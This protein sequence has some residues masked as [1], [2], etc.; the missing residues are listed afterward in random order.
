MK[1]L[2]DTVLYKKINSGRM[3]LKA[4]E[5]TKITIK[6]KTPIQ[7]VQ[8]AEKL[9]EHDL[10]LK[11]S[12]SYSVDFNSDKQDSVEISLGGSEPVEYSTK[13]GFNKISLTTPEVLLNNDFVIKGRDIIISR[14]KIIETEETIE[15]Y[16]EGML[17]AHDYNSK[18]KLYSIGIRTHNEDQT[19]Q[20]VST[21]MINEP[22]RSKNG[23]RDTIKKVDDEWVIERCCA[24]INLKNN[25]WESYSYMGYCYF[26]TEIKNNFYLTPGVY[27]DFVS[28][29]HLPSFNEES[30][31]CYIRVSDDGTCKFVVKTLSNVSLRDF[32]KNITIVLPLK[33]KRY[34]RL[35]SKLELYTFDGVTSVENNSVVPCRMNIR[36]HGFDIR[37]LS[38]A[39]M[40]TAIYNTDKEVTISINGEKEYHLSTDENRKV[41]TT[42]A[43]LI[44]NDILFY[45]RGAK[46]S[47]FSLLEG[48]RQEIINDYIKR[49]E[50]AY[51]SEI[52]KNESSIY[53]NKYKIYIETNQRS[54]TLYIDEPLRI[55]DS[56]YTDNRN[57]NTVLEKVT[58]QAYIDSSINISLWTDYSKNNVDYVGY[59]LDGLAF[60]NASTNK[61]LLINEYFPSHTLVTPELINGEHIVK[62]FDKVYLSIKASRLESRDVEGL[63]KWLERNPFSIIYQLSEPI[64]T[65][66]E[67]NKLQL[68]VGDNSKISTISNIPI[69]SI[70]FNS[71]YEFDLK[72]KKST[73]YRITFSSNANAVLNSFYCSGVELSNIQVQRGKNT[74]LIT[75]PELITDN[76]MIFNG[77]GFSIFE[78]MITESDAEYAAY[79]EGNKYLG[80]LTEDNK[81]LIKVNDKEYI[82]DV[83]LR[84]SLDKKNVD[85][86]RYDY[87]TDKVIIERNVDE[88]LNKIATTIEET[89]WTHDDLCLTTYDS[90]THINFITNLPISAHVSN[91]GYKIKPL[92]SV[93]LY[94]IVIEG[95]G[96]ISAKIDDSVMVST[97]DNIINILAPSRMTESKLCLFGTGAYTDSVMAIRGEDVKTNGYF[98]G[99]LSCFEDKLITDPANKNRGKYEAKFVVTGPEYFYVRT[100]YLSEPLKSGDYLERKTDGIYHHIGKQEVKLSEDDFVLDIF[101]ESKLEV[102]TL[103]PLT[104]LTTV[105]YEE[106]LDNVDYNT[107][108]VVKFVSDRNGVLHY[109]DLCGKKLED[110]P[111]TRG[112]NVLTI[113]T[114]SILKHNSLVFDGLGMTI[115]EVLIIKHS[116]SDA[117]DSIRYFEGT[118]SS[119]ESEYNAILNKYNAVVSLQSKN[120]FNGLYTISNIGGVMYYYTDYIPIDGYKPYISN[121]VE[122]GVYVG[123]LFLYDKNRNQLY[124]EMI[125]TLVKTNYASYPIDSDIKYLQIRFLNRYEGLQIEEGTIPTDYV[126]YYNQSVTL[127]LST[128]LK[129]GD[130]IVYREGDMYHYN[131]N[132]DRYEKVLDGILQ[133]KSAPNMVF[134][135]CSSVPVGTVSTARYQEDGFDF[136]PNTSYLLRF[137]AD[138]DGVLNFISLGGI[139]LRDVI[140]VKGTNSRI[141]NMS[142]GTNDKLTIDGQGIAISKM[143]ITEYI[144]DDVTKEI[145]YF[146]GTKSS[147]DNKT[148][149]I[150]SLSQDRTKE[151]VITFELSTPLHAGEIIEFR[152]Y[153]TF[154][155]HSDGREERL[156]VDKAILEIFANCTI[157]TYSSVPI[158]KIT[159]KIYEQ[160][161]DRLQPVTTYIIKFN[162]SNTGLLDISLGGAQKQVT[163][164]KGIN[165]IEITTPLYLYEN[166]LKLSAKSLILNDVVIIDKMQASINDINNISYFD[167]VQ[168]VAESVKVDDK[169]LLSI[170]VSNDEGYSKDCNVYLTSPLLEYDSLVWDNANL[171]H[172]HNTA[173][174][175]NTHTVSTLEEPYYETITTDALLLDVP[176]QS[177][178][179][180]NSNI[181]VRK[182][183]TTDG[184]E[185]NDISLRPEAYYSIIFDSNKSGIL[186]QL[187]LGGNGLRNLKIS[188]GKNRIRMKT[189]KTIND[190]SL[191]LKGTGIQIKEVLI[192]EDAENT[193]SDVPYFKGIRHTFDEKINNK[194]KVELTAVSYDRNDVYHIDKKELLLNSPL[195]INDRLTEKNGSIYHIHKTATMKLDGYEL[196]KKENVLSDKQ[197]VVFSVEMPDIKGDVLITDRFI[198]EDISYDINSERIWFKDSRIYLSIEQS[199]IKKNN[200]TAFLEES[201]ITIFYDLKRPYEEVV[202]MS[203]IYLKMSNRVNLHL[204][205]SIP[206]KS[207]SL[208]YDSGCV[209]ISNL[210]TAAYIISNISLDVLTQTWESDYQLSEIEW[211][212]HN[213]NILTTS[214]RSSS[215][216]V[217]SR[218]IQAKRII[219]NGIYDKDRMER[220]ID[221]YYEKKE[222]T[223]EEYAELKE[224]LI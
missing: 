39:Q 200:I 9:I 223:R 165:S 158:K 37:N 49:M 4:R 25:I 180:I 178:I 30:T 119:Y 198:T 132:T 143:I 89:D 210:N 202:D 5:N 14:V 48:D 124:T 92:E 10:L 56:I 114:P 97:K 8:L 50:S 111:V 207:I 197:Y 31:G 120:L 188:E 161:I 6:S 74:F 206:C 44:E 71:M 27:N 187:S 125:D 110:V 183:S 40:Y 18:N 168:S 84:S 42:P 38:P 140:V 21:I 96:E 57:N 133:L 195:Y 164:I 121:I 104:L 60:E 194:Y 1:A 209:N 17:S 36:N 185:E 146:E 138:K 86:L 122:N 81:Y 99:K 80:E 82:F 136:K 219:E 186:D 59:C 64:H 199:K 29:K 153:G 117:I 177:R 53:N 118:Q 205:T 22:L 58:G 63:Y 224:M 216:L 113:V 218:Y 221:R 78:V 69:E 52:V 175:T 159:S 72:L 23:L 93:Q 54:K 171:K 43:E 137:D 77:K 11:P 126:D 149:V 189:P 61:S 193:L 65:V 90:M 112:E 108:Y 141:V 203:P 166:T 163:V 129:K 215:M 28:D 128:P 116:D 55:G 107:K 169:Y 24:E 191:K 217:M 160:Q 45:G 34:E 139:T 152:Q 2:K 87:K 79:F 131:V 83:P 167:T 145:T 157:E 204:E 190:Y 213:N 41:I 144:N 148:V 196:W 19:K 220:Q 100:F 181:P 33:E 94:S 109:I 68:Q 101:R 222:L 13:E 73:Q 98:T 15:D 147:Y 214:S 172:Y 88:N 70:S 142:D 85:V 123:Q 20:D 182:I 105:N 12:T 46:L 51:E 212:L 103:I 130:K 66:L 16:F 102:N 170:N 67:E 26:I 95:E 150:K 62:V 47:G 201:P 134:N 127:P 151:D 156:N 173:I 3:N 155:V 179:K 174:D 135:T 162:A 75:T 192:L 184:F 32:D 115:K 211:M 208:S 35:S 76:I 91:R 106:E 176:S 154:H 7:S